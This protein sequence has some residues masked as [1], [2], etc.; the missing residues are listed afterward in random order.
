MA[1]AILGYK[2]AKMHPG[3]PIEVL[4]LTLML[5]PG[6]PG[7]WLGIVRVFYWL[8]HGGLGALRWV[9][10]IGLDDATDPLGDHP[11][12]TALGYVC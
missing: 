11:R 1:T 3:V 5:D 10:P 9:S 6:S 4:R 8:T 12:C 2:Q 7:L